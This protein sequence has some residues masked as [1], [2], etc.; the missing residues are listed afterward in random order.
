M[1]GD[2]GVDESQFTGLSKYFNSYTTRGR[3]NWA[4]A[5]LSVTGCVIAYFT[6]FRK[7][8]TVET[9]VH[10]DVDAKSPKKKK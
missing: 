3:S 2:S 7:K 4:M 10:E 9:T 6:L 8:A 5:T 1:A